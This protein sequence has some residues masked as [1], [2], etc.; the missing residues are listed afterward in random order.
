MSGRATGTDTERLVISCP[1]VQRQLLDISAVLEREFGDAQEF[2]FTLRDGAL[3][4]LQ[5]RTAKRT[6]WAALRIA[7][8][9]V[10]EGIIGPDEALARL[11]G[12]S[13]GEIKRERLI[14]WGE[15]PLCHGQGAGSGATP[16]PRSLSLVFPAIYRSFPLLRRLARLR[17][18]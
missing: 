14:V 12:L 18:K 11:K 7:V 4:L 8:E 13:L 16:S 1:E 5:T 2:E 9:L 10:R 6:P 15:E 3:F 17:C